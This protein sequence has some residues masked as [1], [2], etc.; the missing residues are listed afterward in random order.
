MFAVLSNLAVSAYSP[1]NVAA[2]RE[3]GTPLSRTCACDLGS[4]SRSAFVGGGLL[5]SNMV[6]TVVTTFIMVIFV[7]GAFTLCRFDLVRALPLSSATAAGGPLNKELS[8][9]RRG[10]TPS[11]LSC[12]H[13][14]GGRRRR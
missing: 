5:V 7:A 8:A 12:E 2:I 1:Y 3:A 4:A 9:L 6:P 14:T 13:R 11:R 10:D